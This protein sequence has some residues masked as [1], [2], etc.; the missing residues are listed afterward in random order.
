MSIF[1]D[2]RHVDVHFAFSV[3]D[4]AKRAQLSEYIPRRA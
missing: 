4:R 1:V 3:N 2:D